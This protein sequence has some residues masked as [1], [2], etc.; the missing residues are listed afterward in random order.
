[1][2]PAGEWFLRSGIQEPSGGVARY[3]LAGEGANKPVSTEITGYAVSTLTY[4]H[5]VTGE[6]RYLDA[7]RRAADYLRDEAWDDASSTFPFEPGSPHAYFFD[8]GII[9]R[10]LLSA[11]RATGEESYR[12]RAEQAALSL[13]FDFMTGDEA[14]GAFHPILTL[15]E[16]QP[17]PR[18]PR[19]S[20]EPG[21]YQLKSALLWKELADEMN[22]PAAAKMFETALAYGLA[23][24]ETFLEAAPRDPADRLKTMDRLHA[25]SYFLEALLWAGE[26]AVARTALAWGVEH[27][28][29]LYRD[30]APEFARSDVPAQILR[31]RLIAHHSGLLELDEA[32]ARREAE[33][34]ARH[35]EPRSNPDPRVAGGFWFGEKQ[36]ATL[37][38]SNPV[39]TGF[40]V[41]ALQLWREHQ[42]ARMAL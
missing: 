11:W 37:P 23:T 17:L 16:K 28:A 39:S 9:G 13:A 36:G 33:A 25:Y 4:L 14:Q 35:Q 19:W 29:R 10:G 12:A 42:A 34:V 27:A 30:I 2:E 26:H 6:A 38:F 1:M 3:Y 8:C 5:S 18:E 7:A 31:V 32:A 22:Q 15:P 20:R 40:C 41:Q 21:C 24:H